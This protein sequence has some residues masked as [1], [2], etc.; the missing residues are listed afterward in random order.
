MWG[1]GKGCLSASCGWLTMRLY[2]EGCENI[3]QGVE[4]WGLISRIGQ[5][6]LCSALQEGT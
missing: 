2:I 5:G 4:H 1:C 3:E 6:V